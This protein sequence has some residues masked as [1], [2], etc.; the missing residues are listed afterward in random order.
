MENRKIPVVIDEMNLMYQFHRINVKGMSWTSFYR[1]ISLYTNAKV[2]KYFACA[3]VQNEEENGYWNRRQFF[4]SLSKQGVHIL[5]GFT[6]KNFK[7]SHVEKGVDVLVA[8]QIYKE[9]LNGAKDIIVCSADSDLVPAILEA[10]SMGA[11]VHVVLS[12]FTTCRELETVADRIISLETVLSFVDNRSIRYLDTT[13]PYI[14]TDSKCF[15]NLR[16]GVHSA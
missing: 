3:N 4:D 7:K 11:R 10:Q 6:V 13:K 14:K 12:D 2:K 16:K 1:A 5:E 8:L 15:K 9:A